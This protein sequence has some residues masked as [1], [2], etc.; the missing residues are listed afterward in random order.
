MSPIWGNMCI[1]SSDYAS[2]FIHSNNDIDSK[3]SIN[4]IDTDKI[5][6]DNINSIIINNTIDNNIINSNNDEYPQQG[7]ISLLFNKFNVKYNTLCYDVKKLLNAV[8]YM[9]NLL[10]TYKE[11][12]HDTRASM[13]LANVKMHFM[14]ITLNKSKKK[15]EHL[16]KSVLEFNQSIS[17][18]DICS[19]CMSAP[20]SCVYT[21][22]GHLCAC[23]TCCERMGNTCPICRQEG[24]FI[25]VIKS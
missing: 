19:I 14:E 2:H 17:P 16:E 25:R 1:L 8:S 6:Y 22:C 12:L 15:I 23:Y 5:I 7:I 24:S 9:N 10:I 11:I 18:D 20:K 4:N 3:N 21:T 13:Q